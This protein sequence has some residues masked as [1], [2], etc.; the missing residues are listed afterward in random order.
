MFSFSHKMR[1]LNLFELIFQGVVSHRVISGR[2]SLLSFSLRIWWGSS[3]T[4][5]RVWR[6]PARCDA[7]VLFLLQHRALNHGSL[8]RR[9]SS[10]LSPLQPRPYLTLTD[11]TDFS[12][13]PT[14]VS[15]IK[16]QKQPTKIHLLPK[17]VLSMFFS[18]IPS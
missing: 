17:D 10:L 13:I 6:K 1:R 7:G 12:F 8:Q 4:L 15:I 9:R 14:C 2:S 3:K 16:K 18:L 11:G 5:P